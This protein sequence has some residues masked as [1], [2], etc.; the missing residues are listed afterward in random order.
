MK[1]QE[2]LWPNG[3]SEFSHG[4]LTFVKHADTLWL[5][6]SQVETIGPAL[7]AAKFEKVGDLVEFK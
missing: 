1:W 4:H 5:E 2:Y 3:V 6:E 7:E